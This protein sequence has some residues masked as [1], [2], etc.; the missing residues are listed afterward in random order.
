M[1]KGNKCG[2]CTLCCKLL[3][4][5]EI[6]KEA[7]VLCKHCD[8]GV[9]CNEYESRPDSCRDFQCAYSQ[10]EK[11]SEKLRPDNCGVIFERIQDDIMLG[12]VDF[13]RKSYSD[14]KGQIS[15]FISEGIN[16]VMSNKGIP[17]IYNTDKT[18]SEDILTR[19]IEIQN[20]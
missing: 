16:V 20:G 19:L 6:D 14:I 12:T 2:T 1:E 15:Y 10:M 17:V 11:V 4:V 13:H 7:G 8:E 5:L 18:K 3:V 9:G